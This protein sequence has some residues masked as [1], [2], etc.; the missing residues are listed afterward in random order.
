VVPQD[1]PVAQLMQSNE[2][3]QAGQLH[4]TTK[5]FK[6]VRQRRCRVPLGVRQHTWWNNLDDRLPRSSFAVSGCQRFDDTRDG[7]PALRHGRAL[8]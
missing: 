7:L 4:A 6:L 8:P 2:G 1:G 3:S 5:K